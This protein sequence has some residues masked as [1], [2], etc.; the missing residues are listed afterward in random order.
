METLHRPWS[1]HV[2]ASR[3]PSKKRVIRIADPSDVKEIETLPLADD[4]PIARGSVRTGKRSVSWRADEPTTLY[5]IE[6]LD[7]GDAAAEAAKER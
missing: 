6:A 1:Y 7:G 5:A 2:S 4:I 3:F